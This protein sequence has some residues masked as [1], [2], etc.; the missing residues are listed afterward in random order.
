MT[1][2]VN[3]GQ[4]PFVNKITL[5]MSK[6]LRQIKLFS[7]VARFFFF[8][9]FLLCLS[10]T[11]AVWFRL[12]HSHGLSSVDFRQPLSASSL[13]SI[14][15]CQAFSWFYLSWQSPWFRFFLLSRRGPFIL[16]SN[17]YDRRHLLRI[18]SIRKVPPGRP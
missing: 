1:R 14:K 2:G 10:R 18:Y 13:R 12:R 17:Q 16:S 6:F 15:P 5:N 11:A 4:T 9:S 8:R 3:R 7:L